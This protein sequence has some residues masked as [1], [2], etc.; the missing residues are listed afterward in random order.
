MNK[1]QQSL[2]SFVLVEPK[3]DEMHGG[4]R[5]FQ[6]MKQACYG[7]AVSVPDEY[8]VIKPGDEVWYHPD[9]VIQA[10]EYVAVREGSL[11][12][13]MVDDFPE[14]AV[15]VTENPTRAAI[16]AE[17]DEEREYQD[18]LWGKDNDDSN[19]EANWKNYIDQYN[20]AHGRGQKYKKDF[21]KRMVKVAALAVAAIETYD[22]TTVDLGPGES[23][24]A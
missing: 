7:V 1:A 19:T 23:L 2:N 12:S 10:G 6:G 11:I 4:V 15:A 20:H 17:L 21:R 16:F 13:K 3:S 8:S 5:V 18:D 24:A 22:R 14:A 9:D